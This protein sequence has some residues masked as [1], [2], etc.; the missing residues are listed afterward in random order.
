MRN[1]LF[2]VLISLAMSAHNAAAQ[3]PAP[4][5]A[6]TPKPSCVEPKPQTELRTAPEVNAF[7]RA[8][9]N[10]YQCLKKFAEEQKK[11]A[12]AHT[13]A[14]NDAIS[15]WNSFVKKHAAKPKKSQGSQTKS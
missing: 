5:S 10:Y 8:A 3:Q 12:E 9:D 14:A 4:P 1:A 11:I 6:A 2:A 13:Q 15:K 7:A